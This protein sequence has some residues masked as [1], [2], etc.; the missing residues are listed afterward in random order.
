[1][2]GEAT[3][4]A[5]TSEDA[6]AMMALTTKL[7]RALALGTVAAFNSHNRDPHVLLWAGQYGAALDVLAELLRAVAGEA[8]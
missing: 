8:A 7:R 2:A 6:D 3:T 1:M 4:E 5:F